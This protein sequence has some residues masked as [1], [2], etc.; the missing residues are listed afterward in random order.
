M[1]KNLWPDCKHCNSPARNNPKTCRAKGKKLGT[2]NDST[3]KIPK[4]SSHKE[5]LQL[6]KQVSEDKRSHF[7]LE[8]LCD[9]LELKIKI[10]GTL[11]GRGL[12]LRK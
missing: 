9:W 12:K 6:I 10:M 2:I 7:M 1:T 3:G 8:D 4:V 11:A 5:A